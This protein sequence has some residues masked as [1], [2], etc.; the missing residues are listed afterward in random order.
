[1]TI[2]HRETGCKADPNCCRTGEMIFQK[3]PRGGVLVKVECLNCDFDNALILT[4]LEAT[5]LRDFLLQSY[6]GEL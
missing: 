2:D 5:M 4:S 1:M 6:R 3:L